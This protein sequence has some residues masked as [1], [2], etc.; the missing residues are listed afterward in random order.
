[1]LDPEVV[2][3]NTVDA[4]AAVIKLLIREDDKDG[5]LALLATNEHGVTTEELQRVHGGLRKG[6]D[7]VVIVDG[8]GDPKQRVRTVDRRGKTHICSHQLV[9]LLLLLQNRGGSVI[10]LISCQYVVYRSQAPEVVTNV[11]DFGAGDIARS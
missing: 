2:A 9:G 10:L 8:I 6:N 1:M 3:D 4:S 11:L 5:V 7:T